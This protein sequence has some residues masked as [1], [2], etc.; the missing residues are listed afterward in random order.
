MASK[1]TLCPDCSVYT[2]KFRKESMD[3]IWGEQHKLKTQ[4]LPKHK[5]TVEAVIQKMIEYYKKTNAA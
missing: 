1:K 5:R 3:V 4:R 2:L